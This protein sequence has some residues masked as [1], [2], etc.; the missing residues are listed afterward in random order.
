M[1]N[2]YSVQVILRKDKKRKDGRYPL[3]F[4][5]N[6]NSE[7]FR[8]NIKKRYARIE[9]W[10]SKSKRPNRKYLGKQKL[11]SLLN[12]REQE[13]NGFIDRSSLNDKRINKEDVRDFYYCRNKNQN[14]FFY[15][16]DKFIERKYY[17]A[18]STKRPYKLLRNQLEHYSQDILKMSRLKLSDLDYN[19]IDNFFHYLRVQ[20]STGNS[21][22]GTRRKNLVTFLDEMVKNESINKNYCKQIKRFPEKER[23]VFLTLNELDAFSNTDLEMGEKTEGLEK[24]RILYLFGCYTGLRFGDIMQ[25]KWSNIKDGSIRKVQ[26][27]T[28]RE[29]FTPLLPE[30]INILKEFKSSI[31]DNFVFPSRANATINRDLK[32]IAAKAEINKIVTFHS[33]RH[34]FGTLLAL[35]KVQAFHI[36]HLMGHTDVRMTSRYVNPNEEILEG[37][38]KSVSFKN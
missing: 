15:Q 26:Q 33:S 28:K 20:K 31:Q 14:D 12:K 10:D 13:I 36:A 35:N 29:V 3:N 24:S 1:E 2:S 18:A 16:F 21:G 23:T 5:I 8:L 11:E 30:A 9:E 6:L 27:K 19:F 25:L 38:M 4:L 34:T 7:T 22:L 37:V 17:L 32:I